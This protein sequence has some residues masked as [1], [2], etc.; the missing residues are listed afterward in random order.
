MTLAPWLATLPRRGLPGFPGWYYPALCTTLPYHH[1]VHHP[2]VPCPYTTRYTTLLY[3]A[4]VLPC[5]VYYPGFLGF[6]GLPLGF[7]GLPWCT[8]VYPALLPC[9]TLGTP[10]LPYTTL[11]THPGY[12]TSERAPV[13]TPD[14]ILPSVRRATSLR[15]RSRETPRRRRRD[16]APAS[17]PPVRLPCPVYYPARGL[18]G[19][20]AQ[21]TTPPCGQPGATLPYV[22]LLP[23]GSPG[24]PVLRWYSH[25]RETPRDHARL[26][27][28]LPATAPDTNLGS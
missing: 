24:Y 27:H 3:P 23:A 8:L 21:C 25:S 26:E 17:T 14:G 19:Y 11:G 6:L 5:P 22:L 20:P 13:H 15:E 1:P 12:T 9:P 2:A 4:R 10:L 18:P 28:R 16:H 7:P